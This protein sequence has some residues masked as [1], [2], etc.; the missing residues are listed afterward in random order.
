MRLLVV[1]LSA[2]GDV[3]ILEPVL[4]HRAEA[5]PEVTF[6]VAGPPR[7]APLFGR[8]ANVEYL[9]TAK[10]QS[11]W[12]LFRRFMSAKPDRVADMHH[13]NR[14]IVASLLMRL[15][16]VR[17]HSIN[18][19]NDAGKHSWQRYDDVFGHCGLKQGDPLASLAGD[20][21]RSK[22][23]ERETHTIGIAPFA[24]HEGKIWPLD[25]ME[26][27][28]QMLSLSGRWQVLLLGG[29]SDAPVLEEWER[30]Y[31]RV[32]SLAGKYG[33]GEE[34]EW[35]GKMDL[36]VSMDSANMHF[37]SCRGVPVVSVWGGTHPRSG[38]YGWRQ[39]PQWA[40]QVE[41]PCRPCSKYGNKPCRY[42]DCRC[43]RSVT[44]EMVM[45]RIRQVVE[46]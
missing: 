43:L 9:P 27:L 42:G 10:R 45:Q 2:L 19:R 28:V 18:K 32:V 17:I 44:P 31:P 12:A 39:D 1:R 4:R 3:A 14:V 36:M 23:A 11:P 33:F 5:N 25:L 16:G 6:V 21:W 37:A 35:M 7:L 46:G 40:V 24:Q 38:F 30:R 15:C 13:V 41:M 26:K 22:F 34:L 8:M 20:Y 29:K